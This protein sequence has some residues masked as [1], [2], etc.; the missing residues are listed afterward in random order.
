MATLQK[1]FSKSLGSLGKGGSASTSFDDILA[2]LAEIGK[3]IGISGGIG[4]DDPRLGSGGS[5]STNQTGIIDIGDLPPSQIAAVV[6]M[7]TAAQARIKAAG[8]E[9]DDDDITAL[10]ANG[11]FQQLIKGVDQRLLTEAL[12]QLT[13]VEK[14]R[15]ELEQQRLQDVTRSLVTQVGPIQSLISSPVLGNQGGVLSGQGL[16][17][18]PR[19][20]NFTINV[21]IN[22]SGMNLAQLQKY[23][24]DTISKAWIDAGRGG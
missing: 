6:A 17:A 15:L 19:L 9:V 3:G 11:Q 23:I 18:D 14:K 20:G 22:W 13:E 21:P 8:G 1:G 24:Y 4:P 7:A 12:Q 2:E 5:S 10:L 16:N